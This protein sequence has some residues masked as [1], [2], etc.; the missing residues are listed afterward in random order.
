MRMR[1]TLICDLSGST[2]FF[3]IISEW[4]DLKKK[5]L[6][7]KSVFWFSLQ[8]LSETFLLL[9]TIERDM[10]NYVRNEEILEELMRN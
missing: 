4:H 5:L 10:I 1:H 7:I 3:H 2:K 6:K 9:K 8:L